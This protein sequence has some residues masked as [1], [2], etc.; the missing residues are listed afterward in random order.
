MMV[1]IIII[2]VVIIIIIIINKCSTGPSYFP[3][4]LYF[5]KLLHKQNKGVKHEEDEKQLE[6][7]EGTRGNWSGE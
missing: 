1:I 4:P 2:I 3:L 6:G 5:L 7:A